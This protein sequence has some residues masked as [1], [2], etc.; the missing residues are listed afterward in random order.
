MKK[1]TQSVSKKEGKKLQKA[2]PKTQDTDT[3]GGEKLCRWTSINQPPNAGKNKHTLAA[4]NEKTFLQTFIC[5]ASEAKN[6]TPWSNLCVHGFTEKGG[7]YGSWM[8]VCV[9]ESV[10]ASYKVDLSNNMRRRKR[11]F[12][13]E[14]C[15]N[16]IVEKMKIQGV[17]EV[18]RY[19][20]SGLLHSYS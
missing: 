12:K 1:K 20:P 5:T 4:Y 18:G 19:L 15:K 16:L 2:A 6:Q 11:A 7:Y 13:M 3:Q 14:K 9:C 10:G 17:N 8:P